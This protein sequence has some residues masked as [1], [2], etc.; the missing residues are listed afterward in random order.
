MACALKRGIYTPAGQSAAKRPEGISDWQL[1]I[2]A[3]GYTYTIKA[4]FSISL[5]L[6]AVSPEY[7]KMTTTRKDLVAK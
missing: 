2:L 3:S 4:S 7:D 1:S 5:D 6:E